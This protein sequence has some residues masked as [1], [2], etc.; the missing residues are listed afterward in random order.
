MR[1][2]AGWSLRPEGGVEEGKVRPRRMRGDG[3]R[4]SGGKM[5]SGRESNL[6]P[7]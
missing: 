2:E 6:R 5:F 3:K 1:W 4:C 7:Q